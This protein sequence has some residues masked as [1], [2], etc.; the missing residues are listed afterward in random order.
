MT[1]LIAFLMAFFP[2]AHMT[3]GGHYTGFNRPAIQRHDYR[4]DDWTR[5]VGSIRPNHCVRIEIEP[6]YYG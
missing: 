2:S 6:H 4:C 1:F 3:W 5:P